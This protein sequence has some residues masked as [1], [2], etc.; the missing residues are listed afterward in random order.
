MVDLKQQLNVP[1][2][3]A[4]T[5][6]RDAQAIARRGE[7]EAPSGR[8]VSIADA[9][10]LAVRDTQSY[11]PGQHHFL[12][13]RG[14]VKTRITVE[15]TTTLAAAQRLLESGS[16]VV[17]LNFASA[18]EPGGGF[19][20]GARAQEEYLARSSA[21]VACLKHNEMYS[22]HRRAHDAFYSDYVI[23]S[24]RVP[25]FRDD[26][27]NLLDDPYCVGVISS[28]AVYAKNVRA[29]RHD[30]IAPAMGRRISKVL[31]TGLAHGHRHIVL[32]AWG[33]GAFG[34]EP[35]TIAK[36]FGDALRGP[37]A[38]CYRRVV[39]AVTDWSPAERFI[40][41]FAEEF[42]SVSEPGTP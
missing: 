35:A 37:F 27:G 16:E 25:V 11:P 12:R 7:Y 33:C 21:L 3:V 8:T 10:Q 5:L 20:N 29:N 34:N 28:P 9:V 38:G 24:P 4:T 30:E 22:Y 14:S 18:T 15:N 13:H 2:D 1:R 36:L 42:G 19:L 41:P 31:S 39:F 23:Y 40:R 32:G 17:V 26:D 6:G